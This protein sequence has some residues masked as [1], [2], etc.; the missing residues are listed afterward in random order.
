MWTIWREQNNGIFND[1]EHCI[2]NLKSFFFSRSLHDW[3]TACGVFG[4][5]SPLTGCNGLSQ[6]QEWLV[7]FDPSGEIVVWEQDDE[8]WDRMPLD[9]AMD[10]DHGEQSLAILDAI[11]EKFHRENMIACQKTKGKRE[12]LNLKS[13]IDSGARRWIGKAHMT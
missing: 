2:N 5:P 12:L 3:M 7:G 9:W 11:E 8:F 10:G 6:S 13:S 1:V 4:L